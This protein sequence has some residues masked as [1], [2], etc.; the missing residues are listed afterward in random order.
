MPQTIKID[1]DAQNVHS[2]Q[3]HVNGDAA[4]T[5]TDEIENKQIADI[6]DD[7][8]NSAEVSI[9]GGSDTEASRSKLNSDEKGH[10]RNSSSVKKPA[11]FKA[12]SVNKTF[13]AAK[14]G[15]TNAPSKGNDK[16]PAASGASTPGSSSLAA[17]RPRLIAKAPSGLISKSSTG[18]SGGKG[19]APDPNAV[20]N[21]NRR[22]PAIRISEPPKFLTRHSCPRA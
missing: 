22:K 10:G 21:K 8:V 3:P 16:S 1:S 14:G 11:S 18:V 5:A 2:D 12:V 4:S 19:A 13:L 15:S 17:A 9:S 6:V 20:W 7:L